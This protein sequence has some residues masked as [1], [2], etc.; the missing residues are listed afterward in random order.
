ML[1]IP[2]FGLIKAGVVAYAGYRLVAEKKRS[3]ELALENL[4]LKTQ[5]TSREL[6]DMKQR[7]ETLRAQCAEL[8]REPPATGHGLR[9]A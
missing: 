9:P 6:E 1:H 8:E 2:L 5:T 3:A 7:V 4:E